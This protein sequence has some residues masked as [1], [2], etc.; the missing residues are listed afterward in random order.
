MTALPASTKSV[1]DQLRAL[2]NK[3]GLSCSGKLLLLQAAADLDAK[4]RYIEALE[5][6]LRILRRAANP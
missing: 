5:S 3:C 1:A 6:E 2:V 4:D